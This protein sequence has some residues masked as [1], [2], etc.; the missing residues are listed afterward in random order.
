MGHD[1]LEIL[2]VWLKGGKVEFQVQ[3]FFVLDHVYC[4][5]D[6]AGNLGRN[7]CDGGAGRL[8]VENSDQN[9]IQNDVGHRRDDNKPH[10]RFG[11]TQAA[12]DTAHRI[13]AEDKRHTDASD[14]HICGCLPKGLLRT[15]QQGQDL[16]IKHQRSH[17][18]NQRDQQH[19]GDG[20]TDGA[21]HLFLVFGPGAL[22]DVNLS[23]CSKSG[24]DG[25]QHIAD[26]SAG[27]N[28]NGA[29]VSH[30]LT[31]DD[32]IH[33]RIQLLDQICEN[34]RNGK[35][36]QA[37][38]DTALRQIDS[39]PALFCVCTHRLCSPLSS[40]NKMIHIDGNLL[41]QIMTIL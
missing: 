33:Q 6:K 2:P 5:G 37:S 20:G 41:V 26:L 25:G 34:D 9:N 11:F 18:K 28:T 14:D 36:Q 8:Q 12:K 32:Q 3:I 30:E 19:T 7:G 13:V 17:S 38:Q 10:G 24:G 16:M 39:D 1:D 23:G 27:G 15:V 21:A 35:D 31:D 29:Y 4:C 40:Q 22:G